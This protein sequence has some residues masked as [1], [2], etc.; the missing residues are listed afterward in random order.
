MGSTARVYNAAVMGFKVTGNTATDLCQTAD[1]RSD[2][3]DD[4]GNTAGPG[5]MR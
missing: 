1:L 5:L 4:D 3:D 2:D